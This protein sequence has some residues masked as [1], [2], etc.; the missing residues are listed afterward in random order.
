MMLTRYRLSFHILSFIF[1][2]LITY[3]VHADWRDFLKDLT[4]E[5]SK[6]TTS[7]ALSALSDSDVVAGLKEAL[8]KGTQSA[9][10]LL[11]RKDGFLS[12]PQVKIP[13]PES[14]QSVEK[15]LRKVGQDKYADQF[16]ETMNRA[17]E[18]A[19][20]E[21][22]SI[23]SDSI[24]Q[25]SIEDAKKILQGP[26]DAATQYFRKTSESALRERFQ[27]IVDKST[28]SVGVT[29]SYK[30]LTG[31]LGMMSKFIDTN[32][33]D[34]NSYVTDKALDGLFTMIAVE[35]K[36]IRENPVARTTD[37]LKK[38]FGQ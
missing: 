3:S 21:A 36:K 28:D 2:S 38:V 12:N 16:V 13:M 37:L 25:M 34:L 18:Q 6:P 19:V 33:L 22:V 24:K 30:K 5:K 15:G 20:P 32:K 26:D 31:K 17:A 8:E 27:P 35:E 23:F 11:G 14:L 4:G 10:S 9:V 29:A 7:F 1:F